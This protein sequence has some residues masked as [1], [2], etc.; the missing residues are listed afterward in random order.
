MDNAKLQKIKQALENMPDELQRQALEILLKN[1]ECVV[2]EVSDGSIVNL[3]FIPEA[4]LSEL[5][6]FISAHP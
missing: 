1:K 5:A 2:N 4:T 6:A 3:S